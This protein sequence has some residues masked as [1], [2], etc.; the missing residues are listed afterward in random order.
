MQEAPAEQRLAALQGR[1][2]GFF[3]A[4]HSGGKA[5]WD[6]SQPYVRIPVRGFRNRTVNFHGCG[7]GTGASSADQ[8]WLL[9][10]VWLWI[11]K[12]CL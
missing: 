5:A 9:G 7:A 3:R 10:G 4:V 2:G 1:G 6:M 11:T 12:S 8:G